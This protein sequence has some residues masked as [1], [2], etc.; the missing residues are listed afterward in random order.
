[1]GKIGLKCLN[2]THFM[3]ELTTFEHYWMLLY[4]HVPISYHI[5]MTNEWLWADA[6]T[7]VLSSVHCWAV[8]GW[9]QGLRMPILRCPVPLVY[10]WLFK[11]RNRHMIFPTACH[12]SLSFLIHSDLFN[13][14]EMIEKAW[15]TGPTRVFRYFISQRVRGNSQTEHWD[16]LATYG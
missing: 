14:H 7:V 2:V 1:M 4:I 8:I 15:A 10:R 3:T 13:L 11:H 6:H 9:W 16:W 12:N 5:L